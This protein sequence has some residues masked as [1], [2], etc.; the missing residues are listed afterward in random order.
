MAYQNWMSSLKPCS[1][2]HDCICRCW[3]MVDCLRDCIEI[4]SMWRLGSE[5]SLYSAM[6]QV[7]S[8]SNSPSKSE[9]KDD[10]EAIRKAIDALNE[11]NFNIMITAP[12]TY[13][14]SVQFEL[15]EESCGIEYSERKMPDKWNSFWN[16]PW[17]FVAGSNRNLLP[18]SWW[19][20]RAE[21]MFTLL[22]DSISCINLSHQNKSTGA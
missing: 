8:S 22:F 7:M 14:E 12:P 11:R 20:H 1:L 15:N 4:L 10:Y 19:R 17:M 9:L 13:D 2:L 3:K 5:V 21:S 6:D 16:N 18:R